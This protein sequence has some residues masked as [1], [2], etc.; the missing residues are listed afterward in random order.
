VAP[1]HKELSEGSGRRRRWPWILLVVL[2]LLVALTAWA[3]RQLPTWLRDKASTELSRVLERPVSLAEV[4]LGLNPLRAHIKGFKILEKQGS[5]ASFSVESLSTEVDWASVSKKYPIIKSLKIVKP[6]MALTR[7]ADGQT[8]VDDLIKKFVERPKGDTLP[9]F[10]I[11][12]IELEQGAISL[13]DDTVKSLHGLTE[14]NAKLPF[15][16]SL[17]VDQEVWVKP[18]L[19]LKLDGRLIEAQAE[20][21]PFEGSHRSRLKVNIEPFELAPWLVY[22]PKTAVVAPLKARLQSL[23]SIDFTQTGKTQLLIAGS[24]KLADVALKQAVTTVVFERMDIQAQG[25]TLESFELRPLEQKFKG[26]GI[27]LT[28]PVVSLVRH[29]ASTA[30]NIKPAATAKEAPVQFD[31]NLGEVKVID[32]ELAYRD[33]AFYPKP[34]NVKLKGLAGTIKGLGMDAKV[35][36]EI[37]AKAQ[38]DRG[39]LIKIDGQFSKVGGR[40]KLGWE[41]DKASLTDWWWLLE[42]YLISTPKGGPLKASGQ[43]GFGDDRPVSLEQVNASLGELRLKSKSGLDWLKLTSLK[44]ADLRLDLETQAISLKRVEAQKLQLLARRNAQNELS[45]VELF[46]KSN[47]LGDKHEHQAAKRDLSSGA[48]SAPKRK[49]GTWSVRLDELKLD[50]SQ[51]ALSDEAKGRDTDLKF[52]DLKLL[53]KNLHLNTGA[54]FVA[55]SEASAVAARKPTA[56]SVEL[57]ASLNQKG[58]I[59]IKGP[60]QLQPIKANLDVDLK[61]INILPFQTYFTSFVNA[62]ITQGE[63]GA[64]GKLAID[65]TSDNTVQYLGALEVHQF[66]SV[67][68]EANEDLLKWKSLRLA[69][70]QINSQPLKIDLG[71]IEL[72]EFYSR[73]I[74]SP[75]GRFNLQ[76]LAAQKPGTGAGAAADVVPPTASPATLSSGSS[77]PPKEQASAQTPEPGRVTPPA[78]ML[79]SEGPTLASPAVPA[80]PVASANA[81]SQAVPQP[82]VPPGDPPPLR[83]GKITLSKGNIDFSDFFV[84]P[85]YSANLTNMAG[86]ITE[87]TPEKAGQL[88]LNGRIDGTGTLK[89]E[90]AINPLIRNL[91]LDL[92]ADATDID[93]PR[94]TPYSGK[95]IGYGI[96]KGKLS[97]KVAYK[98]ENRQLSAENRVILDQLTFGDKV[99]SPTAMKLPILFAVAL[100]KDRNGVIDIDMPIGGSLDDPKFSVSG[101]VLRMI[102]NLIVKVI[103]SP[104]SLLASLGGGKQQ[105]LSKVEFDSGN[106]LLSKTAQE[107]LESVA[108]ALADRPA[109]KLDL[110]GRASLADDAP[111]LKQRAFDRLLKAQ[112][113]RETLK[114]NVGA[115]AIDAVEIS[116]AEYPKYLA[117]AFQASSLPKPRNFI[118]M[119]KSV[120]VAD[121]EKAL[122]D[123]V[124]VSDAEVLNLANRRAQSLKDWLADTG[125]IAT[126]RLFITAPKLEGGP[127]VELSLK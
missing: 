8:S 61:D 34:L 52:E 64:Q 124:Q 33:P 44:V 47:R 96:E 104:F 122:K 81:S 56:S 112:K 73:L 21:L 58:R 16:S 107:K 99:D 111:T 29:A 105:E 49:P 103:T 35:P 20:S 38:A 127:R 19:S 93:L 76:D 6:E 12:N 71:D 25:L 41:V 67:T 40:N 26:Q 87:L 95:Y 89:I 115:E 39:E 45:F 5:R 120:P 59:A 80:A 98:L 86:S 14:L 54:S 72:D 37:K 92:K 55:N 13:Q 27:A 32:G 28:R 51:F 109:L 30:K 94:L 48:T 78:A 123:T 11:A 62:V 57:S 31:W 108:K 23:L 74:I 4:E 24:V 7:Y 83:I 121:M 50:K 97:A 3:V 53:V 22:W 68:K 118:G 84:K 90:G 2:V 66:A 119:Q 10:S 85:N 116:T 60:V 82:S 9:Q 75:A 106:A 42:P 65:L 117:Q 36:T 110:A 102:G 113:L 18:A 17:A 101:L 100:L 43:V 63:A 79:L 126:D 88:S 114:G 46:P 69:S 15:L 1:P 125:K 91:F 70:T 77:P